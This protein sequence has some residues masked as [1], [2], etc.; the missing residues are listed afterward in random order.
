MYVKTISTILFILAFNIIGYGQTFSYSYTD[1]CTGVLKS[2]QVPTNGITVNYY[3]EIQTFQPA[4]FYSGAFETWTQNVYANYGGDNPCATIVGLS[5]SVNIAQNT[6]INFIGIVNSLSALSDMASSAGSTNILSGVG[7]V[8]NSSS[9][10]GNKKDKN[11]SPQQPN[12]SGSSQPNNGGQASQGST[13]NGTSGTQGS[14]QTS[15]GSQN[16]GTNNG[17]S[18]NNNGSSNTS[19][20]NNTGG[21]SANSGNT[22][23]SGQT[24]SGGSSST[25]GSQT[26]GQTSSGGS[27]ST[28]GGASSGSQTSTQSGA[29]NTGSNNTNGS[30]GSTEG[31]NGNGQSTPTTEKPAESEGKTNIVGGSVASVQNS[32]GNGGSGAPSNKNGN[33]PTILASSDFVGFNFKDSDVTAGGKVTGGYTSMRWDGARSWGINADYTTAIKGPNITA[34]YAFIKK[35]RI[36]LISGTVTLG[37]DRRSSLYGT[38]ALGQ[39]WNLGKKGKFKAVYMLTGSYGNVYGEEFIGTAAIA[40]TMYDFRISKRIEVKL[41][42]LYVYAPYVSYY[43]DILLKSPHVVLPIVGTNVSLSKRFKINVNCGGAWALN[44]NALNYTIM[45]G[46]RMLL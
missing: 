10:G 9:N 2:I 41:L 17:N 40:G 13:G 39:M 14:G 15:T 36:D 33:R 16:Q 27:S 6:A 25:G 23:S 28:E 29:S 46:T 1:P 5:S 26:T 24:S 18:S 32:S 21:N 30:G 35:K 12:N 4:D 43:N 22:Q 42:G 45:L 31:G 20:N 44:E 11:N 38:L 3:G 19:G 7:S 8:Q 37:F 34:F